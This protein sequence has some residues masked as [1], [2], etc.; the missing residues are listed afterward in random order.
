MVQPLA[1][2]RSVHPEPRLPDQ[3]ERSGR[4]GQCLARPLGAA[5]ALA[6]GAVR[7]GGEP[8]AAATARRTSRARRGPRLRPRRSGFGPKGVATLVRLNTT[9]RRG[10]FDLAIDL[11]GLLRSGAMALATGRAAP[12][13]A[14]R[15]ARG[16][17]VVVHTSRGHARSQG[18]RRRSD[19]GDR[20]GVR[21]QRLHPPIRAADHHRGPR[22]AR[23]ALAE[24]AAPRVVLNPGASWP[25]KR[26]PPEHFAEVARRAVAERGAGLVTVGGPDDRPLIEALAPTEA[27]ARGRPM[28]PDDL[29]ATGRRGGRGG[30]VPLQRHRPAPPRRGGRCAGSSASIPAPARVDTVPT[31]PAPPPW[32]AASRA[33]RAISRRCARLSC[34]AELTPDRVW[35]V[36]LAQL[37]AIER[38]V[39]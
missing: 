15:R 11:Q 16:R 38:A 18:A 6:R 35:P 10:R 23:R 9:L 28:R 8:C 7:L 22:W 21:R 20:R 25:T 12:R 5:C 29:A 19:A 30:P 3:A 24:V 14:G 4:R 26:W 31:V 33:R 36:V 39:R 17:G 34:F 1:D 2:L 37:D 13:R 32:Q 27:A